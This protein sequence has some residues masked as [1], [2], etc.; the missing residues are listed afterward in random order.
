MSTG[1]A[2]KRARQKER[3]DARRDE[4]KRY[5]QKRRRQRLITLGAAL[6]LVAGGVLI[7]LFLR[8]SPEEDSTAEPTASGAAMSIT[9]PKPQPVACGAELP[10]AAGSKKKSYSRAADQKLDPNKTYT[11]RL[12]TSCGDIEIE[13]DVME[14]PRTANSIA[15]LARDGFYNGLVFHRIVPGF[16]VQGGDPRGDGSGG[17]GYDV[18]EPPPDDFSYEEGI[19]AMA[20]TQND[21]RGTSGSQF[22]IVSGPEAKDLP[23]DYA[24]AGK[25]VDGMDVVEKISKLGKAG[26]A[27]PSAWV[28]IE[29]ANILES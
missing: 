10:S 28:Y 7:V 11:L 20:K 22:F 24:Y 3:R 27:Q 15:F 13:L 2:Q 14:S 17:A 23:S 9:P 6:A 29:R 25:V 21:P 8:N 16:V 4:I 26:D 19:V 1:R 18:V 12:E 5:M